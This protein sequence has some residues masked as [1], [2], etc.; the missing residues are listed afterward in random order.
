LNSGFLPA[1]SY[2]F[3]EKNY[4]RITKLTF[5]VVWMSVAYGL[6]F[7]PVVC[8]FP[9]NI[10]SIWQKD[11]KFL[12]WSKEI[13]TLMFATASISSLKYA[14]MTYLQGT[15]QN[16]KAGISGILTNVIAFP[17]FALCFYYLMENRKPQQIF[18]AYIVNDIF[19]MIISCFFV[20][21]LFV[22]FWKIDSNN[23]GIEP[24]LVTIDSV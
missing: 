19:G 16:I 12:Y 17:A 21:P 8:I 6:F 23:N 3:G 13:L 10:A 4:Q 20:I 22:K 15:Q 9:K 1:I 24:S 11:D 7:T 5:H 18:Y 14:S 2:A